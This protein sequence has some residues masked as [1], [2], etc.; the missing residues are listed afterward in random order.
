MSANSLFIDMILE[1][2]LKER[3]IVCDRKAQ[4][5]LYRLCFNLLMGVARRYKKNEEDKQT[6]VNNAFI[7][8]ASNLHRYEEKSSF[9]GWVKRIIMNE[10]IDDFRKQKNYKELFNQDH[11]IDNVEIEDHAEVDYRHSEQELLNML[12]TLP[13]AT[14]L[15]FSMFAIDGFSHK[16]I[17]EQLNI[18]AETSK[19]H[20]KEA[21]KILKNILS[22]NLVHETR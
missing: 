6:L 16:E 18:S 8:I 19:W 17:C 20:M 3:V 11:D 22:K 12:E 2:E 7:K 15:V 4:M 5:E 13:K 9:A 14:K 1:K 21:R 10:V